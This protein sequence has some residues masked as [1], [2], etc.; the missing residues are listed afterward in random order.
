MAVPYIFGA[1]FSSN[2]MASFHESVLTK[3]DL[4]EIMKLLNILRLQPKLKRLS[5]AL[6]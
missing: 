2:S 3:V 4:S 1:H 5:K 6:M